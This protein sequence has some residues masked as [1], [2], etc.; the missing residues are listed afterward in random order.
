VIGE[1]LKVVRV[2]TGW[3]MVLDHWD[4]NLILLETGTPAVH[5]LETAGW[6]LLYRDEISVVYGR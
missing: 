4:V 5:S 3:E 1:W 2:E 6:R